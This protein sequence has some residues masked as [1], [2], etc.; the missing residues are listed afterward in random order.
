[1]NIKDVQD[2]T[3]YPEPEDIIPN[4]FKMQHHLMHKEGGYDQI[5]S[6]I[7]LKQTEDVP[8]DIQSKQGQARLKDFSWRTTEELTEAM[9]SYRNEKKDGREHTLE[10]VVDALHFF[11]E[12][13]ILSGW[14]TFPDE[15]IDVTPTED[16]YKYVF[17]APVYPLGIACNLLKNKA[18]KKT[19]METDVNRYHE[20]L[21][22][23]TREL[24]GVFGYFDQSLRDIYNIY[25]KKNKVNLFRQKSNY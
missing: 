17:L 21:R 19:Q 8:V 13:C 14:E 5:E 2:V 10:E 15:C 4:I 18:W 23:A 11:V 25:Y 3:E 16:V 20:Q 24:L 7:G 1:M 6:M 12:L 9:E 22:I